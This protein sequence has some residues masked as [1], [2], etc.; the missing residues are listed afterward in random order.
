MRISPLSV[1][2]IHEAKSIKNKL[3]IKQMKK[4]ADAKKAIEQKRLDE[5]KTI[6]DIIKKDIKAEQ[7]NE[8]LNIKAKIKKQEEIDTIADMAS[9]LN[10]I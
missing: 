3:M 8:E 2:K 6:Q 7:I 10:I 9:L 5:A 1:R 4:N